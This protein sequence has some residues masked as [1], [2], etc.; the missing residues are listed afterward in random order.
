MA[1]FTFAF[2]GSRGNTLIKIAITSLVYMSVCMCSRAFV[3]ACLLNSVAAALMFAIC[4]F[5]GVY[6]L[7]AG[8]EKW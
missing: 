7:G 2:S 1:L 6:S 5:C 8:P 3:V 4:Y